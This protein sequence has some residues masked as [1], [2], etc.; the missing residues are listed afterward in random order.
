MVLDLVMPTVDGFEVI[1]RLRADGSNVPIVVLTGKT[2]S[3][4][5]ERMLREGIARV[6]VKGGAAID[7]VV[8]EAKRVVLEQRVVQS[9]RLP[10]ILYVEDSP[11]NR[12]IVRRYLQDLFDV[13][14]AED[15]E[16]G[17][18]RAGRDV[19]DLILMDLSL[20]RIDGWEATR[21]LKANPQLRHIPVVA[22]TA[23]ASREDQE[24]ARGAGCSDYLTKPVERDVLITTIRRHLGARTTHA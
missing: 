9:S 10:R 16:H 6:V 24:R 2:L 18:H 8:E 13:I 3:A 17:L 23:H 5:E 19:P 4:D 22:V 1:R 20:P 21:R 11:Q 14:E 12:D 7:R 15:G